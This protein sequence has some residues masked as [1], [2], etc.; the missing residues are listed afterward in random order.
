VKK[1][2]WLNRKCA[3]SVHQKDILDMKPAIPKDSTPYPASHLPFAN[4]LEMQLFVEK[5]AEHILGLR[6]IASTRKGE[7]GLF[8][9]YVLAIDAYNTPFIIECKWDLIRAGAIRQL[10]RYRSTLKKNWPLFE[11]RVR[12]STGLQVAVKRREPVLVALGYRYEPSLLSDA[13]SVVCLTY[14]YH[15]VTVTGEV[16]EEQH[17]GNV[18]IQHAHKDQM[19]TSHHPKVNK[20]HYTFKRLEQFPTQSTPFSSFSGESSIYAAISFKI[21]C[22]SRKQLVNGFPWSL[23]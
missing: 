21:A 19:P 7:G 22:A 2:F 11:K 10:E 6:V 4:E 16:V 23:G 5:H 18:S 12:E 1:P 14:A 9:I 15:D 17:P 3:S 13:Q 20:E 8:K